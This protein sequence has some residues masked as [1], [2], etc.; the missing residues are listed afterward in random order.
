M[1]EIAHQSG[2]SV[3]HRDERLVVYSDSGLEINHLTDG[4]GVVVGDVFCR[5][6]PSRAFGK[7]IDEGAR[8]TAAYRGGHLNNEYWGSY[9]VL[10]SLPNGVITCER[11][12]FCSIN[13]YYIVEG[14]V[15]VVASDTRLLL[16]MARRPPS[17]NWESVARHLIWDN[18]S[19]SST[20]LSGVSEIRCGESIK[21]EAPRALEASFHW[22]PWKFTNPDV[23]ITDPDEAME[24][25]RREIL[26]CIGAQMPRGRFYALDL[27][28]GLDSSIIAAGSAT[29]GRE[30]HAITMFSE[31]NDGD[32]RN[33]ARSVASHLHISLDEGAPDHRRPDLLHSARPH[34]PRPHSRSF[35]QETDRISL[36]MATDRSIDT[37]VN[38]QGGDA[39]FCHLQS[40]GPAADTLRAKGPSPNFARTVFEVARANQCNAWDLGWKAIRKGWKGKHHANWRANDA[41]LSKDLPSNE[42]PP[43]L[44]WPPPKNR[45]LPGKVEH[46]HGLYNS[47]YN[48]NGYRRSD[49]MKGIFPLLS[50]P[51]VE[52]CLRIPTWL[53]VGR[54]RSRYIAR[55]AMERDLPAKVAWRI[56]KGGLGQFQLQMLR[57]RR[58]LIRE[59]LMDGLLSGAGI[60]DRSM[61]EQQLKDDLTFGVNDM[62]RILRLCDVE[63]WCRAS[64][65]VT[66]NTAP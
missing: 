10:A 21:F 53:W 29:A 61:I 31:G 34:L 46:V 57:E 45:P 26:R 19:M 23:L 9:I 4:T 35:V 16:E 55:R 56:S 58:V 42:S 60:L 41:F 20:C 28:G 52:T 39:V 1:D 44:P 66:L 51:L 22:D 17:I 63:A 59:M 18:L 40:S 30:I 50:Q 36:E 62:G 2:L 25:V 24:L 37:F 14:G 8:V 3:T 32:E 48:M 15:L 54:G 5:H 11:S 49:L 12:P 13:A 38:G 27:S 65:Q 64:P 43:G 6:V 33:F 7:N 47:C